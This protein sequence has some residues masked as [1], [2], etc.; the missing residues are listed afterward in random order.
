L[1]RRSKMKISP[2]SA[3]LPLACALLVSLSNC[4]AQPAAKAHPATPTAQPPAKPHAAPAAPAQREISY[5]DL[6]KELGKR[7]TVH[8]KLNTVRSGTLTKVSKT[9]LDM[10]LDNGAELTIPADS[11]RSL[12]VPVPPPDP[13][14]PTAGEPSAKT[15]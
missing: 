4:L 13:L 11:I 7:I 2:L 1:P 8:T 6:G 5:E 10:K 12:S 14:S 9:S 15:K 3:S